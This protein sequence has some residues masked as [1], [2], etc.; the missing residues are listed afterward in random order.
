LAIGFLNVNDEEL[1]VTGMYKGQL[2]LWK[3]AKI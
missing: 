1:P 3:N 2:V